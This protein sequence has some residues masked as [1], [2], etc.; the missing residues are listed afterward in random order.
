MKLP[1]RIVWG[2]LV[3]GFVF[4]NSALAENW[5]GWRGPTGDGVSR[6]ANVPVRWDG[7]SLQNIAWKVSTPG[8]GHSSPIIWKDRLFLTACVDQTRERVLACYDRASGQQLWQ[9]TVLTSL[10]ETKHALNSFASS[11]PATDGELVYVSFLEVDGHTIP[12]PNVGKNVRPITPGT[13][14]IAAYDFAGN[15]RWLVKPG[16]FISAHGYCASPVLFENLVIVN[17]D[18]DGDSYIVALDKQTGKTVWRT[19]RKHQTRSYVTP[20]I[21]EIDGRTQMVVSGSLS[22]VSLD[23][24]NG[25]CHWSIEGP[26]EQFVASMVFDGKLFFMAAGFPTYHVLGIRPDG[27]GDVT[28]THVAWHAKNATCYVPSPVVVNG[29]LL[30]PDDRGTANCFDA[31]T[32]ER[33]WQKRLGKHFSTSLVTAGGLVYFLADDGITNVV[34]PGPELEIVAENALGEHCYS[35]PAISNGCLFLRGEKHLFCIGGEAAAAQ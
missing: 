7:A 33:L 32:G 29:Y 8:S 28:E 22:V 16:E 10:L 17:G 3:V 30:V 21:R 20:I 26:T 2:A 25:S 9:R 35:S 31:A 1:A 11:T 15:Q 6:E 13:M 34:K 4:A 5:P 23:P 27:R 24:R 18:H 12:A 14:V 19:P